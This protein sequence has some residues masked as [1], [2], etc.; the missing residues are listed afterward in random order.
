MTEGKTPEWQDTG[1]RANQVLTMLAA[2]AIDRAGG[3]L[4]VT[5]AEYDA[6]CV[7]YGGAAAVVYDDPGDGSPITARI[8]TVAGIGQNVVT[9]ES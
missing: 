1:I 6:I 7:K 2:I 3:Q 4:E 9:R 8:D 5:Q